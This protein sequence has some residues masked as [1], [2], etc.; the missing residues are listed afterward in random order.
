LRW[1]GKVQSELS[2]Q[3]E[4][5][6][7]DVYFVERPKPGDATDDDMLGY[8]G[9][10]ARGRV[11]FEHYA[12]PPLEADLESCW[13]KRM[14]LDAGERRAAR[15]EKR[16]RS[17]AS[18]TTLCVIM[19]S[20]PR[21]LAASVEAR[22]ASPG[23]RGSYTVAPILRTFLVAANELPEVRSTLCLRLLGRGR[24]QA[25]AL[26]EL[27]RLRGRHRAFRDDT[28][29]L[30]LAWRDSLPGGAEASESERE[31][32]MT[33]EQWER[34]AARQGKAEGKAEAAVS[35]LKARGLAVSPAQRARIL[36]CADERVLDAWV[37]AAVTAPSTA[38]LLLSVPPRARRSTRRTARAG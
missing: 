11:L 4:E 12:R 17:S 15:R 35:F 20:L 10:L 30:V 13:V 16:A 2:I 18:R 22:P 3:G 8:L 36:A 26:T 27:R 34:R 32:V 21:S 5:R 14:E 29:K 33:L 38:A 7:G 9:R 19:P 28:I 24:V 31:L 37:R 25:R 23:P 1:R 6:R